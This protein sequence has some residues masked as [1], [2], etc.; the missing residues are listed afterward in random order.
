[1]SKQTQRSI[2]Y[3]V[4]TALV[5]LAYAVGGAFDLS[6]TPDV[7]AGLNHLGYPEYLG[8]ILG[9]WKILAVGALLAPGLPRLK[10]WAYAGIVINLTSAAAS[11]AAVNDPTNNIV[12]PL[13]LLAIALTSWATRPAGRTLKAQGPQAAAASHARAA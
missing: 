3:W 12:T 11:H 9:V 2:I 13:V 10:E 8:T 5:S 1:M 4:T 6:L 7:L